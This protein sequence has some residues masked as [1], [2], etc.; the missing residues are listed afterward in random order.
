MKLKFFNKFKIFFTFSH[1]TWQSKESHN[2]VIRFLDDEASRCPA[3]LRLNVGSGSQRFKIRTINMDLSIGQQVDIA[4]NLLDLPFGNECV[5]TIICTGV[6][7]HVTDPQRAVEGIYRVLKPGG[8]VY[9]ETP[10]MQTFHASPRDFYRWT[11]DGIKRLLMLF[12]IVEL[13]VVAGPASALAWQFQEVMAML[14]S[15][16]NETLYKAG[17]RFFGWMAMPLSWL[18]CILEKNR[19]AWHAASGLSIIAEKKRKG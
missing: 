11:P 17:L 3:G 1:P 15:L 5:D 18:D 9:I 7:E 13:N 16:N 12:G 6:L 19:W 4:G 2:R 10:F 14:F 8:K